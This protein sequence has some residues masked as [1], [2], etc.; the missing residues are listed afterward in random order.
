MNYKTFGII[1]LIGA[2]GLFM[3][4]AYHNS[5]KSK[6]PIVFSSRDTL[7][8]IWD[9]YKK[10]YVEPSSG[11]TVDHQHDDITTSEGQSY[12]MLRAVW[13]DDQ[14]AFDQSWRWT[15]QVLTQKNSHLFSWLYGKD[16]SG[17]FN[18]RTDIGG[19]NSASDGDSDI[20]L[21]LVFAYGRW[22]DKSYLDAARAIIS[23]IWSRE[24]III[25]GKPYLAADDIEK[26]SSAPGIVLNPSYLSPASY[27]IF[28]SIDRSHAWDKL[29]D[30]SYAVLVDS[31][32][33]RLDKDQSAHIPPDWIIVDRTTGALSPGTASNLTTNYGFDAMRTPWRLALDWQWNQDSR[34]KS[35]LADMGF[36]KNQ[37]T[38]KR[39]ILATYSHDGQVAGDFE[40]P[41]I[42]GASLGYF[43]VE[44]AQ[45]ANAIYQTKLI[46]LYNPDTN[47]W[48][49]M[50]SYYD[51]NWAWFGLALYYNFLPNL[52]PASVSLIN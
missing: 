44:D 35:I 37:W 24:V 32:Q 11:R 31:M 46:A 13:M 36:L 52:A 48:K 29:A 47:S 50:L 21:A 25:Q 15:S 45:D 27:R 42:Y 18:I 8:T 19:Q 40:S 22:Q 16:P 26:T 30:N 28:A 17:N 1:C 12:T 49:N 23:D 2:L 6:V 5:T 9:N 20:A 7:S 43:L 14:E 4:V 10:N 39:K 38:S 33:G 3:V 34:A 51:D 41:A